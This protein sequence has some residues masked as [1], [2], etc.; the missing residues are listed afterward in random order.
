M[1][2]VEMVC[3]NEWCMLDLQI[4]ILN[5]YMLFIILVFSDPRSE[6]SRATQVA[7]VDVIGAEALEELPAA[8]LSS[9]L[10][11]QALGLPDLGGRRSPIS[12]PDLSP[13]PPPFSPITEKASTDGSS[14]ESSDGLSLSIGGSGRTTPLSQRSTDS[15]EGVASIP[16]PRSLPAD[17]EEDPLRIPSLTSPEE[18]NRSPGA[19]RPRMLRWADEPIE[20]V[21]DPDVQ[22]LL[23]EAT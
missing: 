5:F 12:R 16:G 4:L 23:D 11:S 21:I 13:T 19:G 7:Q 17:P 18:F 1:C 14:N 20:E 2:T 3:E 10:G 15:F 22:R 8:D 9:S 6:M